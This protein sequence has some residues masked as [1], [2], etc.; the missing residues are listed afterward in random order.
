MPDSLERYLWEALSEF[1]KEKFVLLTG[2]RQVGKTTLAK[3][4]LVSRNGT[5]LNWDIAVDRTEI[6]S[7][8]FVKSPPNRVLV[9]DELHKYKKWKNWLKGLY[10][11]NAQSLEVVVTGS[12]RLDIFQR[13]GDSLLGR[14]ELLHLHPFSIAEISHHSVNPPPESW[15]E[16]QPLK[17]PTKE[18][19]RALSEFGGFPEPFQKQSKIAYNRWA[20]RRRELLIKEDL[21][22]LTALKQLSLLEHLALLLPGKVGSPLSINSLVSD[23]QVKY[24]TLKSWIE[25]LEKLYFV[26]RIS[27]YH[28]KLGRSLKKEKKLYLWDWAQ[29][30]DPGARFENMVASH[31]YKAIQYWN[32]YGYGR[33]ELC[34]WRDMEKNEVD[35]VI[36]KNQIPIVIIETKYS[37]ETLSPSLFKL[38][39]MLGGDLPLIQLVNT[40]QVDK[41]IKRTRV[42]SA[43]SYLSGLI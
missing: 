7:S 42:V 19:W 22:E 41:R 25:V 21:R 32:D 5:Y 20:N 31:L 17:K 36:T 9:L 6:L 33:F 34:Y 3:Q 27:P 4:W 10:D 23:I 11:A 13:G 43:D 12:A 39:S 26:Y 28:K 35:F 18:A 38:A 16:L 30:T 8:S 14:H 29:V 1:S 37:D 2:P 40:S 24:D 15:L